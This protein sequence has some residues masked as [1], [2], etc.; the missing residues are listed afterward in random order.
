MNMKKI[1]IYGLSLLTLGLS[2]C[3][4]FL[5]EEPVTELDT[6]TVL[7]TYES[8]NKAMLGT[9]SA[10]NDG[11]WYGAGFVLSCELRSGNAKNPTNTDFTSGRY[12]NEYSWVYLDSNTSGLWNYAYFLIAQANNIIN[13]VDGKELPDV[14]TQDLNNIK[15]EAMFLRALSYFD[16]LRTYAQP[17]TYA[18]Q[19]PGVSITLVVD[20]DA[21]PSRNIVSDCFD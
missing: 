12:I 1:M 3:N 6:E 7:S 11:T 10:L 17:Y 16:L 21:R 2:S 20:K 5:T 18:P 9:Y 13:N 19:S 15:G 14:T 8:L 4:G